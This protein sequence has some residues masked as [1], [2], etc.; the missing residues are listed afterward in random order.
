MILDQLIENQANQL[1]QVKRITEIHGLL[2]KEHTLHMIDHP[3]DTN[4][5]SFIAS[6]Y[7]I[8]FTGYT[9]IFG[10]EKIVVIDENL[11]NF[12]YLKYPY[13]RK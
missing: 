3:N 10:V 2:I 1:R 11:H 5:F 12:F 8:S 6:R 4:F 9:G 7:G 13:E